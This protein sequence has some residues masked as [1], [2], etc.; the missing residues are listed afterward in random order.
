MTYGRFMEYSKG[1]FKRH[2]LFSLAIIT[3]IV[4]LRPAVL[5][6]DTI[7]GIVAVVDKQLIMRSDLNRRLLLVG[8]SPNNET[9]SRQILELMIE[10]IVIQKT[11]AKYGLTP[12]SPKQAAEIAETNKISQET[13]MIMI[14]RKSLMDTMVSSRVVVT[15]QMV[16][17]EFKKNSE[18]AGKPSLDLKQ[19][20]VKD[21][22]EK[23]DRAAAEIKQGKPFDEVAQEYSDI[24]TDGKCSLGWM[25]LDDLDPVAAKELEKANKGDVSVPLKINDYWCIFMVTGRDVIGKRDFEEVKDQ[26]TTNLLEKAREN[27]F[28]YWLKQIMGEY[29]IGI[30]M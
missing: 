24:L 7:D 15:P 29:F 27:A 20:A 19:I 11:Y 2:L 28:E 30:Y 4:F 1:S 17:D 25:S 9:R 3:C 12:I 5:H 18:Y 14:M 23:A 22:K 6:A 13:A 26:I 21:D 10:E 16:R 8:I